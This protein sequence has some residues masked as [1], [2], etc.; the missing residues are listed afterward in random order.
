[1]QYVLP[2]ADILFLSQFP[3]HAAGPVES[4]VSHPVADVIYYAVVV[5]SKDDTLTCLRMCIFSHSSWLE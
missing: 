1:M 3:L 5:D 4:V 2:P